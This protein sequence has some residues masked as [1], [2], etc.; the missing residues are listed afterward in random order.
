M[1]LIEPMDEGKITLDGVCPENVPEFRV[2]VMYVSAKAHWVEGT[3][4]DNL[5]LPFQFEAHRPKIFDPEKTN[6]FLKT[7]DLDPR[8]LE[9]QVYELSEGQAQLMHLWRAIQ[10]C[11]DFLLLDE[12]T[13]HLDP[14]R[15]SKLENYLMAWVQ[16]ETYRS[17]VWVTHDDAQ[18]DRV[19]KRK[20]YLSEGRLNP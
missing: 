10:L 7:F 19:A 11:P 1:A 6:E 18:A 8:V 16:D 12:P 13:S 5:Q 3:V 15:K 14:E 17:I 20:I 4:L 2:R 9:K